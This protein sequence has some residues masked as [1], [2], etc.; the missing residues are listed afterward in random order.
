MKH[1]NFNIAEAERELANGLEKMTAGLQGFGELL[2][3]Y[4]FNHEKGDEVSE[5]HFA[6]AGVSQLFARLSSHLE[7]IHRRLCQARRGAPKASR[8]VRKS[9]RKPANVAQRSKGGA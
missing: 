5:V 4:A 2:Q 9:K 8:V 3:V 7:D 1:P 6:V